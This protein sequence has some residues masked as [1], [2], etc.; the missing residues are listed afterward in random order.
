MHSRGRRILAPAKGRV[1]RDKRKLRRRKTL[2]PPR[3]LVEFPPRRCAEVT[4]EGGKRKRERES[5]RNTK[6]AIQIRRQSR[7][8]DSRTNI[9]CNDL[10][11]I[12]PIQRI[13]ARWWNNNNEHKVRLSPRSLTIDGQVTTHSLL[14]MEWLLLDVAKRVSRI[15]RE[16]DDKFVE[17]NEVAEWM[18]RR[19][20]LKGYALQKIGDY[21][22]CESMWS[23]SCSFYHLEKLIPLF[24]DIT[25][26]V[27]CILVFLNKNLPGV[28]SFYNSNGYFLCLIQ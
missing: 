6:R 3:C 17:K 10:L 20:F 18:L 26:I 2:N 16:I 8:H 7:T 28:Q 19:I 22:S 11:C 13:P 1:P 15:L 25:L 12:C 5:Y 21:F 4:R 9:C 14:I 27:S 23:I 24:R